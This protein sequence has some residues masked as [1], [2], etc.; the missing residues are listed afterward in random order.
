MSSQYLLDGTAR[1]RPGRLGL[2]LGLSALLHVI[3]G[4]L[5]VWV[6]LAPEKS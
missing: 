6:W 4:M 2:A 1:S 3:L 5:V